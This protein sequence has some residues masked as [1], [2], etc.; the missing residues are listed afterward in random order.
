[1]KSGLIFTI[2]RSLMLARFKQSLV[3]AIGVT[4]SIMMF[5]S[6]LGFM[7]GLNEML[8]GLILNRTPHIRLFNEI[9]P[10][11]KQAI[12]QAR[13]EGHQFIRSVKASG[14]RKEIYNIGAITR[15]VESDPRVLGC[16]AKINSPV[17]FNDGNIEING[18]INGL[19]VEA[20]AKYFFFRDY[21]TSGNPM[22]IKT[23]S[24]S[25]ILGRGLAN[26][27]LVS[28]GDVVHLT[29]PQGERFSLKVVGLFESG[30]ME[31]DKV[32]SYASISTAQK[33]LGK[34]NN[35]ITDLQIK[36]KDLNQAPVMS[37]EY[38]ALFGCDAEDIQTVN[39]Q[40]ET[41]SRVRSIISYAVG[42]TLLIVAGFGIFNIL[43]MMI[44]EKM[45][46][47]AILKATGF[48]G[49]DVR[50]IFM[51]IAISIGLLGGLAGEITG[52]LMSNLIDNIPFNTPAL[53][54][55]KTFPVSYNPKYYTI[56]FSF[57]LLTTYLAGYFPALK[58]S[59][60]D[61]VVIIRG[62]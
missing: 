14:S 56:S 26:K 47:I 33:I 55:I 28:L 37:K 41:G 3:A 34:D 52:L 62:K 15:V 6:L 59:K 11:N 50:R 21:V 12:E 43:N 35:Y 22:D 46:S 30:L 20:E 23:V 49:K 48:S 54:S 13:E 53:P 29:N 4:F 24:N 40:F 60:V 19:D 51:V 17:F 27:L 39:A 9:K 7:N 16:A 18:I 2:A 5:V 32:N 8:D 25:I 45:E 10:K 58:A 44:F 36:L 31:L 61:P 57:A 38:A 42:I 1:M